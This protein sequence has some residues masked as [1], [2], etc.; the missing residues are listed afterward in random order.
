[1]K[2]KLLSML[3]KLVVS[4]ATPELLRDL[5][6]TLLDVVEDA[7]AKSKNKYDDALV[8]PLCKVCRMAFSIPDND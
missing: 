4:M 3:F 1:M 7:V 5:A 8:L 2:A 6:D